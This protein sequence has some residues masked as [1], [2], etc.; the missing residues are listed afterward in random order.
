MRVLPVPDPG[1]PEHRTAAG[2]LWWIVR[3]QKATVAFGIA[4]GVIWMVAWALMPAAIGRA[5]DA[6][7]VA[8]DRSALLFWGAVLLGLGI[9]QATAGILRHRCAVVNWL[10]ASYRTVQLTVRQAGHLGATLP[11]RLAT[12]EVVSIGTADINHIGN[13]IDITARSSGAIVAI[14]VV[15]VILLSSSMP[16]G[17]VVVLG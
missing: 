11:Q 13:S 4:M 16:L 12:G 1:T 2:Y 8:R 7:V 5:I 10:S 14:I 9:L 6:G 3:Q 17:L 15:T